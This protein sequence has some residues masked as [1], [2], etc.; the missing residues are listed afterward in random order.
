MPALFKMTHHPFPGSRVN[1]QGLFSRLS[2]FLERCRIVTAKVCSEEY[3]VELAT[4]GAAM[5]KLFLASVAIIALAAGPA[6]AADLA[7]RPTYKA[8][9][10][11]V[12]APVYSW[13]GFYA[14]VSLGGRWSDTTWTAECLFLN[15][16][17]TVRPELANFNPANFNSATA[18]I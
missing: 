15:P 3:I 6:N 5:K 10:P 14:G 13:S 2:F 7:A 9:P 12:V 4:W 16:C 8:P 11:P 17:I 18:R 1:L